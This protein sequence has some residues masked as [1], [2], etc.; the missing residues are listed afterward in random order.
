[1]DEY[2]KQTCVIKGCGI[3][4]WQPKGFDDQRRNDHLSF[5]C[6]NGHGQC[7]T[8]LNPQEKLKERLEEEIKYK[9][10]CIE[11]KERFYKKLQKTKH[12]LNG[13]KGYISKLKKIHGELR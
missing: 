13:L 5:Y 12:Q 8:E 9:N 7:Y 11:E 6:P 1:M 3:S 2:F 10:Y 4:W